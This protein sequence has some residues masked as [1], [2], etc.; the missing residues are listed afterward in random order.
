MAVSDSYRDYVLDQLGP[1]ARIQTRKLFGE[2]G[3]YADGVIFAAIADDRLYFKVD[4]DNRSDYVV[5]GMQ[6]LAPGGTPMSYYTVP[7]DVLDDADELGEWMNKA[8]AV[9]KRAKRPAK[10]RKSV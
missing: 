5:R 6:P 2:L 9:A 10:K 7:E 8:L 1:L 4:A 3:L